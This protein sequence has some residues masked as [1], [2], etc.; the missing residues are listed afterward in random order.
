VQFDFW[1]Y[2]YLTAGVEDILNDAKK[3]IPF[4][5]GGIAFTDDDMKPLLFSSGGAGAMAARK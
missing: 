5:G 3:P 4:A 1:K 2:F